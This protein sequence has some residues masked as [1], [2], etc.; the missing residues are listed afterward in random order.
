M[1]EQTKTIP[2]GYK[3]TDVGVIPKDWDLKSLGELFIITSSKR[4]FQSEW[5]SEG[6]PFYRARELAVLGEC[7]RVNNELIISRE[8]YETYKKMYGVP[9]IG[10]M[11]VTGVGTLGKVYVVSD[12]HEFYFKDGNIIWFKI[13][14]KWD[15]ISRLDIES[16]L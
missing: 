3:Q 16:S 12:N 11:L 6:I 4:V 13:S 2:K 8:M 7:G 10:D 9:Q 14:E 5:K 15:T 1:S